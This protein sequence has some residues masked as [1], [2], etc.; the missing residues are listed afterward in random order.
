MSDIGV[1][2]E[3]ETVDALAAYLAGTPEETATETAAPVEAAAEKSEI[4][5]QAA[6]EAEQ[7]EG[8]ANASEEA[9]AS[10]VET[11]A[12]V[13]TEA[14][15]PQLSTSPELEQKL[16][17]ANQTKQEATAAR[18]QY[19][20]R[21][22]AIVPQLEMAVAGEFADLK[23]PEDVFKLM[24]ADPNRYNSF[25]I[26]STRLN[27][28]KAAQQ[29]AQQEAQQEYVKSEQAKIHK[30]IPDMAD[31]EKGPALATQLRAYAKSQGIP[32]NR[33]A[34][35]ADDVILLHKSMVMANEL[36]TL[37]GEKA[38]QATKLAEANKKAANAPHV[39]K[40]GAQRDTNNGDKTSTDFERF[41]KS[42][43]LDDLAA[44][45]SH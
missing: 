33:Q 1:D 16:G 20:Q 18:D 15:K 43:R 29:Q 17:E 2:S 39:Q 28:A 12:P 9:Q 40:P 13:T 31:P 14:P 34:R 4:Q 41:Q 36:A 3:M 5:P 27:Q 45:L 30:A 22:N 35:S 37:K 24:Q 19:V 32:D 25:V 10:A 6:H 26:A 7:T 42:G 38:D 44:Y 8:G 11:R 21:L 23:T